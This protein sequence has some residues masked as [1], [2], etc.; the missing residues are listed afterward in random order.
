MQRHSIN[1][2]PTTQDS[3]VLFHNLPSELRLAIW[4]HSYQPRLVDVRYL[5]EQDRC[6]TG[7]PPPAVLHVCRESRAEASR[8]YLRLFGT[9]SH[10]ATVYFHPR[11]DVLYLPRHAPMGYDCAAR[12]FAQL[13]PDAVLHVTLLALDHVPPEVRRPWELYNKLSLRRSF[14]NLSQSF[15]VFGHG[16]PDE[17]R[18]RVGEEV[19]FSVPGDDD[20]ALWELRDDLHKAVDPGMQGADVSEGHGWF[21]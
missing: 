21:A 11:L 8:L 5:A 13:V 6:V 1:V 14:P 19:D 4:Q 12:E 10:E 18:L 3:F 15:L 7:T 16:L 17:A 20:A 2:S 9:G